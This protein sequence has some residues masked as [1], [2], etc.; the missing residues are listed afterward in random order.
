MVVVNHS[1]DSL[2]PGEEHNVYSVL[3]TLQMYIHYTSYIIMMKNIHTHTFIYIY[4]YIIK[5]SLSN[6]R[7]LVAFK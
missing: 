6:I 3:L 2:C 7:N 5:L 1:N 4:T